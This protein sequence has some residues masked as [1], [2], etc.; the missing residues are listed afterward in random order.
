MGRLH[1]R[2]A[3]YNYKEHDRKFKEQF[4]TH[5]DEEN[6]IYEIIKKITNQKNTQKIVSQ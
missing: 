2:A 6:V 4:T 1:T 5:I 3:E